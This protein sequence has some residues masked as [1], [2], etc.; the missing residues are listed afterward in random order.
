MINKH[1]LHKF[2]EFK[3]YFNKLAAEANGCYSSSIP[4]EI[5]DINFLICLIEWFI[6]GQP[7]SEPMPVMPVE[8]NDEK[9]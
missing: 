6:D 2:L 3:K 4:F 9:I 1:D 8:N 5:Y 7:E